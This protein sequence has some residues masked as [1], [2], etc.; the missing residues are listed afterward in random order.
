MLPTLPQVRGRP[1]EHLTLAVQRVRAFNAAELAGGA[2][3]KLQVRGSSRSDE[4]LL[5]GGLALSLAL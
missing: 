3:K 5:G 1:P 4:M 2:K